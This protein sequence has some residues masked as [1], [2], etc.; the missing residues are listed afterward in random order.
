M[1]GKCECGGL[2]PEGLT[3]CPNCAVTQRSGKTL[4]RVMVIVALAASS[5]GVSPMATYG[6]PLC[7]DGGTNYP[8]NQKPDGGSTDGGP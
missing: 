1:M 5:C 6:L 8:C 3:A 2:V 4:R 7:A